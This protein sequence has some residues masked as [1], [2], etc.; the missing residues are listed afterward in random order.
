MTEPEETDESKNGKDYG[1]G[2]HSGKIEG[3]GQPGNKHSE[4]SQQ[5]NTPEDEVDKCLKAI[6]DNLKEK[7]KAAGL[8][9]SVTAGA[10][11]ILAVAGVIGLFIYGGQLTATRRAANAAKI[12]ADTAEA[13][14]VVQNRPWL[15]VAHTVEAPL[16]FDVP[17]IGSH[18]PFAV[19]TFK[20]QVENVGQ[21]I[22]KIVTYDAQLMAYQ[23]GTWPTQVLNWQEFHCDRDRSY[24]GINTAVVFPHDSVPYMGIR[25]IIDMDDVNRV[26]NLPSANGLSGK[27]QLALAG[28]IAYRFSFEPPTAFPHETSFF[29]ILV[30]KVGNPVVTPHGTWPELQLAQF[31][32][33]NAAD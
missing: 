14:L 24:K 11:A 12:A 33:G 31:I 29:Y 7:F 15:K 4:E 22:A 21:S 2:E 27:V 17:D 18:H 30:D 3:N 1:P 19:M 32:T 10:T 20:T 23:A 8:G 13:T 6:G 28:C 5:G 16:A 26:A 25:G 9:E